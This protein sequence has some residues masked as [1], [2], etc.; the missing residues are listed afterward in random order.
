MARA[1]TGACWDGSFGLAEW[2]LKDDVDNLARK[3]RDLLGAG[4][5]EAVVRL[6]ERERLRNNQAWH[7]I[8]GVGGDEE[9]KGKGSL[10]WTE[11][12]VARLEAATRL[13]VSEAFEG[14]G[15]FWTVH[16]DGQ[17]LHAHVVVEAKSRVHGR[18]VRF[19]KR[20]DAI[21]RLREI[22]VGNARSCGLSLTAERRVD[23]E[24]VRARIL[25]GDEPLKNDRKMVSEKRG[26]GGADGK[27][28]RL[29]LKE[30]E[31]L[32][33]RLPRSHGLNPCRLLKRRP[34]A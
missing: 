15:V 5:R 9:A 32:P 10:R 31:T 18:R 3:A 17:Q 7:I 22:F 34:A 29:V 30:T 20:G 33:A 1:I 4:D 19:D 11:D 14:Y 21:D 28:N 2:D 24:E 26:E 8:L 25:A 13:T 6:P 16:R 27:R 23:R 12:D